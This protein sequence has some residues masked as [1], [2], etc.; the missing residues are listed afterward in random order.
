M[1][2]GVSWWGAPINAVG[3]SSVPHGVMQGTAARRLTKEALGDLRRARVLEHCVNNVGLAANR[4]EGVNRN[5]RKLWHLLEGFHHLRG[6]THGTE[7]TVRVLLAGGR[8]HAC[9][10]RCC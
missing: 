2:D 7:I 6:G 10:G 4:Q 3:G 5:A 9:A 8:A 1:Q